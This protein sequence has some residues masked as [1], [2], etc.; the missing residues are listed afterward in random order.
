MVDHLFSFLGIKVAKLFGAA[1][2]P[3]SLEYLLILI[4]VF[5]SSLILAPRFLLSLACCAARL[6]AV[7]ALIIA[8]GLAGSSK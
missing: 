4:L 1:P 3:F 8:G 6:T 2:I 5:S 7:L